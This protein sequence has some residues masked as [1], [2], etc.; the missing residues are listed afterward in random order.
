MCPVAPNI[1]HTLDVEGLVSLGGS[2][3][4]GRRSFGLLMR[5]DR[6]QSGELEAIMDHLLAAEPAVCSAVQ[7]RAWMG[8]C[9][10]DGC[11]ERG[12]SARPTAQQ[13]QHDE[14]EEE[15]E[16]VSHVRA[17]GDSLISRSGASDR[18][19]ILGP[20]SLPSSH[21]YLMLHQKHP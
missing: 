3:V 9:G 13:Q 15:E 2:V 11:R 6:G 18:K 1:S 20:S 4:A 12:S 8:E 19:G 17:A 16:R 5:T 14:E 10:G 21:H 7:C